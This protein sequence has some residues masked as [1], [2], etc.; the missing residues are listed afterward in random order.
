MKYP[1]TENTLRHLN[2]GDAVFQIDLKTGEIERIE[3]K[4]L[5]WADTQRKLYHAGKLSQS[6][7][8]KLEAL[9]SWKW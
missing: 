9:P 4:L 5:R 7:I 3:N 2:N 8:K 1:M 6:R